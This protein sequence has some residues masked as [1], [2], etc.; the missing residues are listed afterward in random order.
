MQCE[1][2]FCLTSVC[3]QFRSEILGQCESVWFS[4]FIFAD[5]QWSFTGSTETVLFGNWTT[6][7]SFLCN[8][9]SSPRWLVTHRKLELVVHVTVCYVLLLYV[10]F[11][12]SCHVT[13]PPSTCDLV[14]NCLLQALTNCFVATKNR[15]NVSFAYCIWPL[16]KGRDSGSTEMTRF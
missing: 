10:M 2:S 15:I 14:N 16:L 5:R 8:R 13:F 3:K 4:Q 7:S 9:L 12:V 1:R 6:S 11:P